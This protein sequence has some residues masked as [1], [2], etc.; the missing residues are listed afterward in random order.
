LKASEASLRARRLEVRV[1]FTAGVV[2]G[3][4]PLPGQAAA[5]AEAAQVEAEEAF[6]ER[7]GPV[8][9]VAFGLLGLALLL[10]GP[11]LVYL[12]WYRFGREQTGRTGQPTICRTR[13]TKLA[14]GWPGFLLSTTAPTCKMSSPR[15]STWPGA[16]C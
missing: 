6:Q 13:R 16:R 2:A 15:W 9:T 11:V 3:S 7:W 4:A 12:M 10:G 1:Q 5:D 8:A 14:L